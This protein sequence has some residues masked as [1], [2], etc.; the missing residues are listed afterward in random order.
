[1]CFSLTLFLCLSKLFPVRPLESGGSRSQPLLENHSYPEKSKDAMKNTFTQLKGGIKTM[2]YRN[3]ND[4]K[5]VSAIAQNGGDK[6]DL[7]GTIIVSAWWNT[8]ADG[9]NY[10][11]VKLGDRIKLVAN[12]G[13]Q[14]QD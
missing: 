1:M 13:K 12:T 11:S 7:K 9:N 10:L 14:N 3:L 8:D 5:P 4:F 2:A 6:P